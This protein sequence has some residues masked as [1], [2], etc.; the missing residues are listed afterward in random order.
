MK[1]GIAILIIVVAVVVVGVVISQTILTSSPQL[2]VQPNQPTDTDGDGLP[3]LF[4]RQLGSNPTVA[5]SDSDG[6]NDSQDSDVLVQ[7]A[8]GQ[9]TDTDSDG[10]PDDFERQLGSNPTV[11]D[12][13]GD[14]VADGQDQDS[15]RNAE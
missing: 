12:S 3:D 4:E 1:K 8:I 13:D 15:F 5:D 6:I 11:A 2:I 9:P 7:P 14:G 10:L